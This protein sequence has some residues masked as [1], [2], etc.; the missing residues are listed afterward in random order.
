MVCQSSVSLRVCIDI[1]RQKIWQVQ[2]VEYD[3]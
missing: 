3:Y 1:M 2:P